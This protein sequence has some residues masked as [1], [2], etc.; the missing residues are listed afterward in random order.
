MPASSVSSCNHITDNSYYRGNWSWLARLIS[1]LLCRVSLYLVCEFHLHECNHTPST[2]MVKLPLITCPL[3][4]SV[5]INN[6]C[7]A[8]VFPHKDVFHWSLICCTLQSLSECQLLIIVLSLKLMNQVALKISLLSPK[9]E[10][11]E[12]L[13]VLP[14]STLS[15]GQNLT[16]TC[17]YINSSYTALITKR[18]SHILCHGPP[19]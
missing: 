14:R 4:R 13:R 16:H 19:A 11:E 6:L 18:W 1:C 12:K 8:K 9:K 15:G 17:T 3:A 2:T 7:L 5:I 10:D